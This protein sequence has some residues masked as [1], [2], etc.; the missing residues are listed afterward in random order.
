VEPA[1]ADSDS[2]YRVRVGHFARRAAVEQ[3]LV[4]LE[5]RRAEKLWVIR[6]R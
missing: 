2:L 3:I 4:R 6:E 1:G 5:K